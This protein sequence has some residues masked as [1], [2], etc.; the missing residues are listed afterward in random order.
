MGVKVEHISPIKVALEIEVETEKVREHIDLAITRATKH[1]QVPGFRKGKAPKKIAEK[2]LNRQYLYRDAAD[3]I[4]SEAYFSAIEKE[5]L[6][7]VCQ[8][9]LE[10]INEF[11]EDAPFVFK[12][13]FERR[14]Q[15]I[16]SSY[17]SIDVEIQKLEFKEEDVDATLRSLQEQRVFFVPIDGRPIAKG[18]FVVIDF[19]CFIDGNIIEGGSAKGYFIE[20]TDKTTIPGFADAVVGMNKGEEKEITLTLPLDFSPPHGGK[21]AKFKVNLL[22][23]KEKQLPQI[24]DDFAKELGQFETLE[25]VRDE[26]KKQINGALMQQEQSNITNQV[27]KKVVDAVTIDLPSTLVQAKEKILRNNLNDHLSKRKESVED[28]CASRSITV[29]DLNQELY[30]EASKQVKV[31]LVLDEIAKIENLEVSEKEIDEELERFAKS[32]P[33]MPTKFHLRQTLETQGT[34]GNLRSSI[35]RQ[36][37]IKLLASRAKISYLAPPNLPEQQEKIAEITQDDTSG[38]K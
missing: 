23:I 14:P 6:E 30:E 26:I 20:V 17:E 2:Y 34:I 36:K 4:I 37:S 12:A 7:P 29:N 13:T 28:Y 35:A 32:V 19:E 24:N 25:Q 3:H 9:S 1:V 22:E 18:D 31:E 10:L 5:K 21:E 33:N 38:P 16:L 27:M 8:P 11:K 15:V